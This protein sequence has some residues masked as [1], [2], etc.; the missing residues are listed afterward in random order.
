MNDSNN[1]N[2]WQLLASNW[3]NILSIT[4]I[5]CILVSILTVSQPLKYR[6]SMNLLVIQG[7]AES[8]DYYSTSKS[9]QYLSDILTQVIYSSSFF[10]NVI[11]S[12]FRINDTFSED[13]KKRK[14]QWEKTIT[15]K[16]TR[17]TGIITIN[18]YST[19]RDQAEQ[20]VQAVSYILK[21]KHSIYH[22]KGSNVTVK[23]IDKPI[24]SNWPVK[25]NILTNLAIALVTGILMG[26][27]FVYTYPDSQIKVYL[28]LKRKKK[29]EIKNKEFI[30]FINEDGKEIIEA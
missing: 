9:T 23:V 25:P 29:S 19:K 4:L 10:D 2:I 6:S 11:N 12:G 20:I 14:K 26:S 16:T 8:L 27:W 21:T 7:N 17:D 3:R 22:G 24:T 5:T 18:A 28:R 15:T 30:D 13:K 1:N